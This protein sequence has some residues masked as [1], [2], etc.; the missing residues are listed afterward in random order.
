MDKRITEAA[1]VMPAAGRAWPCAGV[2]NTG[3]GGASRALDH[4]A[5]PMIEY[6]QVS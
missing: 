5:L 4:S 1:A 2:L 3:F 6:R